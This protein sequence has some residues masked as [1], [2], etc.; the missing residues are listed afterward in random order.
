MSIISTTEAIARL[1]AGDTVAVP[2]ETVYGLAGRIDREATLKQIFAVKQRPFFDPLI[3]HVAKLEQAKALAAKWPVVFDDLAK[4]FWPG[5]LT[6][7]TKKTDKVSSLITSGLDTVALRCPRHPLAL[8]IIEKVGVPLAGP[9][10]NRFGRTSPTRAED[11]RDEFSGDVTVVDGGP[12]EVGLE[13]T[14]IEA[15]EKSGVWHIKILRPGGISRAQLQAALAP[16][17]KIE[18]TREQSAA[19]PGHLKAHYQPT[20]PLV[21]V[22]GT[23]STD[24]AVY[25]KLLGRT[26]P[27]VFVMRLPSSPDL[28]ARELYSRFRQHSQKPGVIVIE[29][30]ISNTGH[31]W[32]AI[33][34]R[35][36]RASSATIP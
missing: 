19:S 36:E 30:L 4:A 21:I 32:E 8:E 10:A 14:V 34:D 1:K 33:W 3:V 35:I 11:V 22:N 27:E 7:V 15:V 13:S 2:T 20:N 17:Y 28:A 26:L 9:S 31:D 18:I 23:A 12:C 29:K 6:L 25:E 16:K 24:K 5:P